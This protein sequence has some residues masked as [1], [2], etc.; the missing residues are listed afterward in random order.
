[1]KGFGYRDEHRPS[2]VV[3]LLLTLS[4]AACTLALPGCATGP[5]TTST[6]AVVPA[7]TVQSQDNVADVLHMVRESHRQYVALYEATKAT[8]DPAT[9]AQQYQT[10]N[11]F[12]NGLDASQALL[13]TWK[14]TNTGASPGTILKPILATAP[15]FLDLAVRAKLLTQAQADVVKGILAGVP[16]ASYVPTFRWTPVLLLRGAA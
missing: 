5:V 8:M 3:A 4:M 14:Q 6:G 10:L 7:A 1:M 15:A 2:F 9:R 13:I 11:D 12:A 16:V